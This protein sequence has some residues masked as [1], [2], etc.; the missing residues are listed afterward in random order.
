MGCCTWTRR[1]ASAPL[2]PL[3]FR[4]AQARSWP[5]GHVNKLGPPRGGRAAATQ[6]APGPRRL[7]VN[8]R[9]LAGLPT[10]SWTMMDAPAWAAFAFALASASARSAQANWPRRSHTGRPLPSL[11][12]TPAASRQPPAASLKLG[13]PQP[14]RPTSSLTWS[15][16]LGLCPFSLG[17]HRSLGSRLETQSKRAVGVNEIKRPII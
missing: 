5:T 7:D 11:A 14:A 6:C 10:C 8:I 13:R 1:A 15:R 17:F 3:H 2:P 9:K 12:E 16:P 4:T